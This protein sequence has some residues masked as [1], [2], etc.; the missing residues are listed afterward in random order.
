MNGAPRK[1]YVSNCVEADIASFNLIYLFGRV[2]ERFTEYI[3]EYEGLHDSAST[4]PTV[5]HN[6]L[7]AEG[8]RKKT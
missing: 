1:M 4:M 3:H 8:E 6:S 2:Q 7:A 5:I